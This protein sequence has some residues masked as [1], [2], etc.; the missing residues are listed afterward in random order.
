MRLASPR[1]LNAEGSMNCPYMNEKCRGRLCG[2]YNDPTTSWGKKDRPAGC[3]GDN[4]TA[5]WARW[6]LKNFTN[7]GAIDG[8]SDV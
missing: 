7:N 4:P 6:Y 3:M 5:Q 8:R 1:L 2:N